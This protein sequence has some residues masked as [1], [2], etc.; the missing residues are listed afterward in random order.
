MGSVKAVDA[1]KFDCSPPAADLMKTIRAIETEVGIARKLVEH[2]VIKLSAVLKPATFPIEVA[3][4]PEDVQPSDPA[5]A[6]IAALT[7]HLGDTSL[8]LGDIIS[9]LDV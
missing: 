2:L 1:R 7:Q 6:A 4:T 3:A 5:D 8:M 9:R